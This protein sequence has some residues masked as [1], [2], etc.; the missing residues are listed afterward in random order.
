L[1]AGLLG[2]LVFVLLQFTIAACMASENLCNFKWLV[3]QKKLA[4][5]L[6]LW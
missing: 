2:R 6:Y 1:K 3:Q 5:C 4:M